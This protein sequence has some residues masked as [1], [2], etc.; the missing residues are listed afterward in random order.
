MLRLVTLL[1]WVIIYEVNQEMLF[2]HKPYQL[3]FEAKSF[4]ESFF[5]QNINIR[6]KAIYNLWKESSQWRKQLSKL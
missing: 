4:F 3:C 5:Y 6:D 1:F 2:G